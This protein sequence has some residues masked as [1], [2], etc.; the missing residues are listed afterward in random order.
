M[1]ALLNPSVRQIVAQIEAI[2]KR[3]PTAAVIGIRAQREEGW[4]ERLTVANREFALAWCPSPITVR[5]QLVAVDEEVADGE[6][7]KHTKPALPGTGRV[8]LTPLSDQCL[9]ADVLARLSRGKVFALEAWDML[10]HVFQARVID[11]RLARWPWVAEALLEN[12]PPGGY[13][14]VPGGVL[15]RDLA[16]SRALRLVLDMRLEVGARP[17]LPTVLSWTL[18]PGA[19]A[20]F[21]Q[22]SDTA[23]QQIGD[24]LTETLGQSG[25]VVARVLEA[26]YG[27][28]LVPI[29]LVCGMLFDRSGHAAPHPEL[30]AAAVRLER[31]TDGMPIAMRE[32]MRLHAAA[33]QLTAAMEAPCRMQVLEL[34]DRLVESLH[35]AEFAHV[36]ADMPSGF[37]AR[38]ARFADAIVSFL[39]KRSEKKPAAGIDASAEAIAA[40]RC[41]AEHR[42]S[43]HEVDRVR[44]VEMAMR[45]IRWLALTDEASNTDLESIA[46]NY[47][48]D[49]AYADWA[50]L[51]LMEGDELA[52]VARAYNGL[53]AAARARRE[54]LNRKFAQLLTAWNQGGC[55]RLDR[56]VPMEQIVSQVLAPMGHAA[57]VLLLVVDG[58]SFPIFLQLLED[59]QRQG[60]N[61]LL[62]TAQ[63]GASVGLATIPSITES[64]RTSLF[65]GQL[66]RGQAANEKTGFARHPALLP[67]AASNRSAAKPIVFHKGDL[68]S[69]SDGADLAEGVRDAIGSRERKVVAVVFNAVDDHLSGPD[70]LNHRW[71]LDHLR[72]IKAL[73][74]EARNAGRLVLVTADHGHVIDEA[75]HGFEASGGK[76]MLA[77]TSMGDRWRSRADAAVSPEECLMSGGRVMA[78]DGSD[79]V[80]VPWSET[81]RYGSRKNG[82]H[83]GVSLQEMLVPIT[84]LTAETNAPEG[85]R[86]APSPEPDWWDLLKME[87]KA[88]HTDAAVRSKSAPTRKA[89]QTAQSNADQQVLFDQLDERAVPEETVN[90]WIDTLIASPV[91][92]AQKQ[93]AARAAVKDEQIRALLEALSERGG[94]L[95]KAALASRLSLPPVRVSGF[96]NAARRLLNVDQAPV[97][98]LDESEGSVSLNRALLDAQFRISRETAKND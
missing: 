4:P 22:L 86:F 35:I 25:K 94:K 19:S 42:L 82:Y 51:V 3:D 6:G 93:W 88:P 74:Y 57:P 38:L 39:G 61:E 71:T 84:I 23:R 63:R 69:A 91:F 27:G 59:A 76:D 97:I 70:Q 13:P 65:C 90:D 72:L 56:V 77:G 96:V 18:S 24:W 29:G 31:F 9:G 47:M 8:L 73:L 75:T 81:L 26:G 58:L 1:T 85:F 41:V 34:A 80:V 60:W 40:A 5:E 37:N 33:V 17:D 14:P 46:T 36:S 48:A 79:Q 95:S 89:K 15:D 64:S 50:R 16:W 92:L 32:G 11:A 44:R 68:I 62:P 55:P 66:V 2:L 98:A 54:A 43:A 67:L 10:R 12:L 21:Q 87:E 7:D 45:L 78:P 83:G 20:S 53:R 28:E 30:S 52:G 49:G